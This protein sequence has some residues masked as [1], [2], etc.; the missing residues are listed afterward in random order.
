MNSRVLAT[1][2]IAFMSV[3]LVS[4]QV[5][6]PPRPTPAAPAAPAATPAPRPAAAPAPA[7]QAAAAVPAALSPGAATQRAVLDK[8]CV[9]CHNER[10][11]TANLKLDKLDLAHLDRATGEKVVRKLRAGVMPPSGMPRP[12]PDTRETLIGWFEGELDR[13]ADTH[14]PPPGLHRLNRTEYANTIRD[15][16]DLEVDPSKF[17][18]S[19][20]STHGFDNMAGTL[21]MSPA[22]IEA[23]LSAA[24]KI[25]R[26]AIGNVTSPT[27]TVYDAPSDTSQNAHVEGLPFGTRGG[28]LAKHEFPADGEYVIK[29]AGIAGYFN[30]LLGQI[31][32]EQLEV[33]IDGERVKVF[34]WDKEIGTGGAGKVGQTARIP[35][36]AGLHTVGVAFLATNDA[37]GSELNKPF[38]RTLNSPGEIPGY[39]FY[40]GVGQIHVEGPYDA[41]GAQDSASRKKIFVCRPTGPRDEEVC[42]RQIITNLAR[43]AYR[44]PVRAEDIGT[45]LEFYQAGRNDGTFDLGIEAALQ[46]I[47]ADPEFIYRGEPE[48]AAL[49]AGRTYRV[50]DLELASRLSYFLWSSLPDEELLTIATQGKLRTP[51]VLDQQIRRMLADPKSKA[52]IENFT[53]QWLNVRGMAAME[54]VVNLFP[55][56]DSTLREAFRKET[57]MFFDSV[58]HED[59]SILDLL[60]ADYTFVNE[61]LAK[62]YGIPNVYGSQ[63][64]R[65]QLGPEMDMRRGLLGKGALLTVTSQAARTS[66]VTRGKWFLQTFLGVSP[67]DPP[68]NVPAIKPAANDAAGNT[69][70]A[71]DAADDGAAPRES[72]LRHLPQHLRAARP[73]ARELRCG[74]DLADRGRRHADRR[75]RQVH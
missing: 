27:Q 18:P 10:L 9:T 42:A 45:L 64:R 55:D 66:P 5:A 32:G 21:T 62:H 71:D 58:V 14:L 59:R 47:L 41:K 56:F 40:P 15:L 61:R 72:G 34:E 65:V 37:P 60:T 53:G 22:L 43:R 8:Y 73:R 52:L 11:N 2:C 12:D 75:D 28:M 74:R 68:P 25:S 69:K 29:V 50:T 24:G 7:P 49:Q 30:N 16:L 20:D 19:D 6:T 3:V 63:F 1:G 57:E 51:A 70:D 17:L 38:V 4:A 44:R 35:V 13:V 54:P 48:A 31:K 46:R 33:T 39:L 26:M 23:Y 67:P 36:K